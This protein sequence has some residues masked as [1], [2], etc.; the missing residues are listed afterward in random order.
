M[1]FSC[2]LF[3][4]MA[5]SY[6]VTGTFGNLC[7][8][9]A[10]VQTDEKGSS[11]LCQFTPY[12]AGSFDYPLS[13]EW[14]LSPQL[15]FSIPQSGRDENI[16]KMNLF[17]LANT[18]YQLSSFH[19]TAGPGLFFTRLSGN[20]G[21]EE[22]NNGTGMTSFPLPDRTI[23]TRNFILNLGMGV[24]FHRYWSADL[25]TYIF[26]LLTSEDR[27]FSIAVSGTYHFGEF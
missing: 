7:E 23:F 24:D 2:F 21:T 19:F 22:L 18:K 11:N 10:Q 1:L 3:V 17:L 12:L 4:P 13:S 15:G 6:D 20:G 26:N 27:A 5:N 14:I 25:Q 16:K 8:Y 9:I